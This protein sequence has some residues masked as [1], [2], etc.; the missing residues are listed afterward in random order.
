MVPRK[1]ADSLLPSPN[2]PNIGVKSPKISENISPIWLKI[3]ENTL[4]NGLKASIKP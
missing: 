4:P 1:P 2:K 3:V